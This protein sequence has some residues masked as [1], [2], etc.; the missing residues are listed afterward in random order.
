VT[1]GSI[2]MDEAKRLNR[3]HY[4]RFFGKPMGKEMFF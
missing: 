2:P 4:K 3:E 1:D